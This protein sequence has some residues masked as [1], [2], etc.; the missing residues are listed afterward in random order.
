MRIEVSQEWFLKIVYNNSFTLY[1]YSNLLSLNMVY[2]ISAILDFCF[3]L[4]YLFYRQQSGFFIYI[5]YRKVLGFRC[6]IKTIS[7]HKK[8]L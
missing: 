1:I 4:K 7:H 3:I 5:T 2:F 6:V 8:N